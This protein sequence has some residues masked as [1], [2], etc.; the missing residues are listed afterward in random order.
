MGTVVL[1]RNGLPCDLPAEW[2]ERVDRLAAEMR[3]N[4]TIAGGV[5]VAGCTVPTPD[6]FWLAQR[7]NS[8]MADLERYH[9][10]EATAVVLDEDD[11]LWTRAAHLVNALDFAEMRNPHAHPEAAWVQV[12]E[13]T[14]IRAVRSPASNR[15]SVF[16]CVRVNVGAARASVL[17]GRTLKQRAGGYTMLQPEAFLVGLV[18]EGWDVAAD[19]AADMAK[20]WAQELRQQDLDDMQGFG[21]LNDEFSHR[22]RDQHARQWLADGVASDNR[23]G[24]RQRRA[25][26]LVQERREALEAEMVEQPV[27]PFL[28]LHEQGVEQSEEESMLG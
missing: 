2:Q 12:G 6:E 7:Q 16:R 23:L 3:A 21:W 9:W 28:L 5:P 20:A 4:R 25:D 11:P 19:M 18:D 13:E 27:E 24:A 15:W 17:S 26:R 10:H 22:E 8:V 1:V 14:V